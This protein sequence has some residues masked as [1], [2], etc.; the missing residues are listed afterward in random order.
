MV[1]GITGGVGSGKSTIN[2]IL[3]DKYG[4]RILLTDDMAKELEEP[5]QKVYRELVKAFGDKILEPS[6]DGNEKAVRKIDKSAFA[7]L[8]YNDPE[9]K[10]QA[11]EIIHPATWSWCEDI[12]REEQEKGEAK[13]V[14][15]S[16]L[17]CERYRKMCDEIWFIYTREEIRIRRLMESRGYSLEKC[18]SIIAG[19]L[20]DE[21][22]IGYAD[23]II[24]NSGSFEETSLRVT[25]L[26]EPEVMPQEDRV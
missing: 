16:A 2:D 13:V 15:E 24:D 14:V 26:M 9:V 3:R 25:E 18:E 22:F 17:P 19:Q 12:I 20:P 23:Y 10:K 1:I 4:Y 7:Y 8:I 5:G 6:A 21:A 11:E